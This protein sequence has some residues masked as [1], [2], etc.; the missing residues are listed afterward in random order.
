M[1]GDL[2]SWEKCL[3]QHTKYH[4]YCSMTATLAGPCRSL[5]HAWW[6]FNRKGRVR[7]PSSWIFPFFVCVRGILYTPQSINIFQKHR[8]QERSFIPEE[9]INCKQICLSWYIFKI[10]YW[11]MQSIF[12]KFLPCVYQGIHTLYANI[13]NACM[14]THS[15]F[16]EKPVLHK[17]FL[18]ATKQRNSHALG[19]PHFNPQPNPLSACCWMITWRN[20]IFII[21][22]TI[23]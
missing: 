8:Q 17:L 5:P 13:S 19:K 12:L 18:R 22:Y 21:L 10:S 20:L 9:F 23:L 14:G 15:V 6:V 16:R 7:M 3:G 4:V 2:Y 11:F 1:A